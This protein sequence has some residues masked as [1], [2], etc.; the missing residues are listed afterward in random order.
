MTDTFVRRWLDGFMVDFES[1]KDQLGELDRLAGDG[2]FAVN[3]ASALRRTRDELD[4]LDGSADESS[5]MSASSYAFLNTGGTSGPLLGMWLRDIA[6]A[7]GATD[8]PVAALAVGVGAGTATVQR[9]GGARRG[10]KTMVDAMLPAGEVLFRA[11]EVGSTLHIALDGAAA[12]AQQG[13]DDTAGLVASLGRASYVG[14]VAVG[15]MDPGAAAVALFFRSGARVA[16][17]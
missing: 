1:D 16:A 12:A 5:V 11:N 2:D 15:V 13:A 9:L 8:D 3:L 7:L 14:D 6:K 4:A 17:S 10:D